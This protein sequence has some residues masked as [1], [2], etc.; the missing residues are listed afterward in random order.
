MMSMLQAKFVKSGIKKDHYPDPDRAEIALIGRSNVGKSSLINALCNNRT[1]AQTSPK[2]GKTQLLNFFDV[3]ISLS[4]QLVAKMYLTD[5]PGYG[6]ARVSKEKRYQFQDMIV[7][8]FSQRINLEHVF[9]LIDSGI[10]PQQID[11]EFVT[12][13]Y[14]MK[15]PFSIVFTK[16]DKPKQKDL[17]MHTK[18]FLTFLQQT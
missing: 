18:A 12:W 1:L 5:M 2:P 8:Y 15:L 10:P 17:V 9:V 4:D 14:E 16:A 13:L 3:Q 6:Y 11:K 7:E